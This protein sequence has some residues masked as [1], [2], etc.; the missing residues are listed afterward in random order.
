MGVM[1][2]KNMS[3]APRDG[4]VIRARDDRRERSFSARFLTRA[5]LALLGREGHVA[6][7]YDCDP[8]GNEC[9]YDV[10]VPT[11]WFDPD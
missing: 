1:A 7:W 2:W 3:D 11:M 9:G 6:G 4:T 5:M 8:F 10:I